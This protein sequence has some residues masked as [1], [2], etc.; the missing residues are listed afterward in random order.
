VVMQS[1][2]AGAALDPPLW[3]IIPNKALSLLRARARRP[4][5]DHDHAALTLV[6]LE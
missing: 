6:M 4:R 5:L 2:C 3:I 1:P